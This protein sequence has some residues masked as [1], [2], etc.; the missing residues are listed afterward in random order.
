MLVAH[1]ASSTGQTEVWRALRAC[2]CRAAQVAKFH[3]VRRRV[4]LGEN[5][6]SQVLSQQVE[7]GVVSCQVSGK[8]H[9]TTAAFRGNWRRSRCALMRRA[10]STISGV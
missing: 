7:E 8:R 2:I 6:A 1:F 9:Q 3:A 5:L 10:A 4:A